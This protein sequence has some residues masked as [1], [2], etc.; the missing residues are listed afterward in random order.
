M[1]IYNDTYLPDILHGIAQGLLIPTMVLIVLLL[2]VSVFFIGSILVEYF[3]ER[4]HFKQNRAAIVNDVNNATYENVTSAILDSNLLR[5][6]KSALI[7]VSKNMGLDEEML[8]SLAQMEV[9]NVAKR[10]NR[11]VAWTDTIS[12]IG[13]LAGLMGTLIPLG[14]GMVALGQG[15]VTSLSNSLLLAFDATICG[16]VCAI[17]ALVISKVRSG[18]YAEYL[19]TLE[20]IMGCVVDKADEARKAGIKLPTNY[21]GDPLEEFVASDERTKRSRKGASSSAKPKGSAK[22]DAG[23]NG[24]DAT[25]RASTEEGT[26][27]ADAHKATEGAD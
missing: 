13:P 14:P 24:K 26:A 17:V 3:T 1:N 15:D 16:L 7:T 4:R 12:K 23:S 5:Y 20:S 10:F 2:L 27:E 21:V 8:F 6:Q 11:R 19:N 25:G 18:W 9:N 22:E